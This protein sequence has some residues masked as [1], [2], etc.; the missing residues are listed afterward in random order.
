MLVM[1]MGDQITEHGV[2]NGISIILF[3]GILS[4]VLMRLCRWL[5]GRGMAADDPKYYFIVPLIV[6]VFIAMMRLSYS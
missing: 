1:W 3:A 6:V 4:A 2:G 5:A